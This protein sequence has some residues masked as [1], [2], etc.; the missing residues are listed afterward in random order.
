MGRMGW[1]VLLCVCGGLYTG[2]TIYSQLTLPVVGQGGTVTDR[3][4]HNI[5]LPFL[6]IYS[7]C[8]GAAFGGAFLGLMAGIFCGSA[9]GDRSAV[10]VGFCLGFV[11]GGFASGFI[12]EAVTQ[13]HYENSTWYVDRRPAW[14]RQLVVALPIFTG[15][16][17][18]LVIAQIKSSQQ[19][20]RRY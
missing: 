9:T 10:I 5:G 17:S 18:A 8:E 6:I 20:H 4:R 7:G 11:V 13:T 3:P 19:A 14:L 1:S 12:V 16:A 2:H 15:V